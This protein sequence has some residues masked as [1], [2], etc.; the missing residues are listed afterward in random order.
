M[1][2]CCSNINE[3]S[4]TKIA[5]SIPVSEVN[6]ECVY[7]PAF[8]LSDPNQDNIPL[9]TNESIQPTKRIESSD[10]STNDEKIIQNFLNI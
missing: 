5:S 2:C 7:E 8:V 6:C 3:Y 9:L 4:I 1:G 10:S